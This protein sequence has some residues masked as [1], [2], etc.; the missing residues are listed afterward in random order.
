MLTYV[1]RRMFSIVPTMLGVSILSFMIM[2]LAPG[3]ILDT[4]RANPHV[5][6]ETI[7]ALKVKFGLDRPW[8]VRY[9]KWLWRM[10]HADLGESWDYHEP[11]GKLIRGRLYNTFI[12]SLAATIVEWAI[13]IPLGIWSA[14]KQYS[15]IDKACSAFAFIGLSIPVILSS[16]LLLFFAA[17]THLFPIGG[18]KA[19]DHDAMS[20]LGRLKD[21]A[22]HLILPSL[23]LGIPGIAGY[24]RIMRGNLLEYLRAD[25]VRTARA[26]GLPERIVIWKHAVRNALNP[27]VTLF[28][29]SVGSL[30]SGAFVVEVIMSWPGLGQMTLTALQKRD[31]YLVMGSLMM[32]GFMLIIGNLVADLLLAVADPR[33]KLE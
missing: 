19:L 25:F 8:L 6:P 27:M 29:Y 32:A 18:M 10:G 26:K 5:R 13:A 30:L 11:V 9:G 12:L 14:A 17:S 28:G 16:L 21:Y 7:T 33:I 2:A 4:L 23:A 24:M 3:D 15:W 22:H 20:L 1:L 31:D